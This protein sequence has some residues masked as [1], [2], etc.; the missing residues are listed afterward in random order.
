[1][2]AKIQWTRDVLLQLELQKF[3]NEIKDLP[4]VEVLEQWFYTFL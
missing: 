1:M 3:V 4:K 2:G